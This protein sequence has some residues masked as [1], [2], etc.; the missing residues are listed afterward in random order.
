MWGDGSVEPL[1]QVSAVLDP[2][3]PLERTKGATY[4]DAD[5]IS[6]APGTILGLRGGSGGERS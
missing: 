3:G 5:Q 2:D 4:L 1:V 6:I